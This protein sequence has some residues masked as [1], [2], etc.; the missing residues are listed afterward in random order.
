M[1]SYSRKAE[2][3]DRRKEQHPSFTHIHAKLDFPRFNGEEDP[4]V[5]ACQAEQFHRFHWTQEEEKT[6]LDRLVITW[7]EFTEGL[8]VCFGPN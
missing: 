2:E 1:F 7:V 5:W 8:F 6:P 3:H 4:T